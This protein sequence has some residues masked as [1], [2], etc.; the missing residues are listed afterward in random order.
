M[1]GF[2]NRYHISKL[3]QGQVNYITISHKEIEVI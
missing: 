3:N 2:L 1:D